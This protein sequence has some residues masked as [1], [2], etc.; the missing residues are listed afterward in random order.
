[1]IRRRPRQVIALPTEPREYGDD[2]M[3]RSSGVLGKLPP[4][5]RRLPEGYIVAGRQMSV[6]SSADWTLCHM[7]DEQILKLSLTEAGPWLGDLDAARL[8]GGL[9]RACQ[10]KDVTLAPESRV[11]VE[12]PGRR[13]RIDDGRRVL[14]V[15]KDR[16]GVL[17][18]T[19]MTL[20]LLPNKRLAML[21]AVLAGADRTPSFVFTGRVTEFQ[22][23]NYMLIE[24]LAEVIEVPLEGPAPPAGEQT[25]PPE[26]QEPAAP[27]DEPRAEDII[28]QLL[29]SKPR[30][31]VPLPQNLPVVPPE[32]A[33]SEGAEG[34]QGQAW[35]EETM[36]VDRP[37]RVVPS[38][39]WWTFAFEDKGRQAGRRPIRVLPNRMLENAIALTGDQ[40]MGVVLLVSGEVTEYRGTNYLL[41]R[42]VLVQR[43]WGNLR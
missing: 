30:R 42:K 7:G 39:K 9:V 38:E 26:A 31:A 3:I 22:A 27:A 15:E 23:N 37:G 24:H 35:P 13:W 21:E 4:D 28:K 25:S 8:P 19:A 34:R 10:S 32:D 43:D 20:R 41:L 29:E 18:R 33:P 11:V 14:L 36:I 16:E 6:E 12:E 1:M 17:L 5:A 2:R 40:S